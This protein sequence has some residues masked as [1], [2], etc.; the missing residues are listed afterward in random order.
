MSID[1]PYETDSGSETGQTLPPVGKSI[2]GDAVHVG[3]LVMQTLSEAHDADD[4]TNDELSEAANDV[5]EA[6]RGANDDRRALVI[7]A[8]KLLL[9]F[10]AENAE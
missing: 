6:A 3:R 8:W 2:K 9:D 4:M 10:A 5:I 1:N 7:G